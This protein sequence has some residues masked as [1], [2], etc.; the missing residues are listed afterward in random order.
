VA[1]EV[2]GGA[3]QK[4][5]IER[6]YFKKLIKEETEVQYQ[7]WKKVSGDTDIKRAWESRG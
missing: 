5:D 3:T 6:L 4:Y 1:V 2:R 7:L